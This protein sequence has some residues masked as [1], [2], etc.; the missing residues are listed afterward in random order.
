METKEGNTKILPAD[1]TNA[2]TRTYNK[3]GGKANQ[4]PTTINPPRPPSRMIPQP[5]A[6]SPHLPGGRFPEKRPPL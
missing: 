2:T 3:D 1:M 5:V 4:P 6:G